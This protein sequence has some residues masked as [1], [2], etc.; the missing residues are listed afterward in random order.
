MAMRLKDCSVARGMCCL[1]YQPDGT[2]TVAPTVEPAA[3][4]NLEYLATALQVRRRDNRE[5]LFSLD[6]VDLSS[7]K[8]STQQKRFEPAWLAGTSVGEVLFQSDYHLKELSMGEYEQPIIGM[9]NCHELCTGEVC[10]QEWSAREWFVVRR[11]E[12]QMSG[13]GVL[14]PCIRMGVEAREQ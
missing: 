2:V 3:A 7:P 6:P 1:V 10:G 5:P 12:V 13:D 9:K 11:A 4:V 8:S 14:L